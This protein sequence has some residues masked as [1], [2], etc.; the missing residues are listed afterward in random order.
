M[1]GSVCKGVISFSKNRALN[2]LYFDYFGFRH[3]ITR[4]IAYLS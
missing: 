2:G 4:F 3:K 1:V